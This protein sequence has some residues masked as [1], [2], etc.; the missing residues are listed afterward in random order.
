LRGFGYKV[1]KSSDGCFWMLKLQ[2][3]V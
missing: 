2:A 1:L 3:W